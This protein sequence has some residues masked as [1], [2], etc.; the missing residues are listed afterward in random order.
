MLFV[1]EMVLFVVKILLMMNNEN[2]YYNG[3]YGYH[4][5]PTPTPTPA[6]TT[7]FNG[8]HTGLRRNNILK[9]V[10]GIDYNEYVF[11]NEI[12]NR[13]IFGMFIFIFFNFFFLVLFEYGSR[14][15]CTTRPLSVCVCLKILTG[16]GGPGGREGEEENLKQNRLVCFF[17]FVDIFILAY[18]I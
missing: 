2:F 11:D 13:M 17:Y 12:S 10:Y 6:P 3:H 9:G 15:P 5:C 4:E 1:M 16:R 8:I 18:M 14:E 7:N